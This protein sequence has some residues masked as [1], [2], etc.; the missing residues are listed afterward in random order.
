M[1]TYE[2]AIKFENQ[3]RSLL[4]QHCIENESNTPDYILVK[5]INDCLDAF[6]NAVNTREVWYGRTDE[7]SVFTKSEGGEGGETRELQGSQK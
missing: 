1:E 4:N 6:A 5:Y 3:L 7:M 2:E